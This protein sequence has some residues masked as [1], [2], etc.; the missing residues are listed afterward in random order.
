MPRNIV[1]AIDVEPDG[2]KCGPDDSW[3]GAAVTVR[4]LSAL[5]NR[6]QEGTG[7]PVRLNWFLR[8]DPQI[9]RTWGR[10]DWVAQA[11]PSLLS[12]ALNNGDFT[13][14][15][16]H[17]WRWH[18]ARGH[19][20]NDFADAAWRA[21]CLG[22]SIEGYEAV[23]GARPVASRFGDR[24]LQQEDIALLRRS[25]IRY[26]LTLEP[27]APAH[28]LSCD[29]LASCHLPDQRRAPRRP[30]RPSSEDYLAPRKRGSMR[31][32]GEDLW[33]VPMTVTRS[34]HW[35]PLRQPPFLIRTTLPLNLVL[36]PRR[37]WAQLSS[38]MDRETAEPI[39]FALRCGDLANP[40]FLASF[41]FVVQRMARHPGL[42]RCRFVGI[43]H[44]V[45][46]FARS[47]DEQG[48]GPS[49]ASHRV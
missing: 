33:L 32:P 36:R 12:T 6:L 48:Q 28:R 23:F 20:Y 39:V 27:G 4:N 21:D 42:R 14:I 43:D 35:M 31:E 3:G 29:R 19:W 5:R 40:R 7:A 17:M 13:G 18:E 8:F 26:D 11:C 25:G 9:E 1:F 24:S 16:V 46:V 44:A 37:V 30:Y 2:R 45:G 34:L 47:Q 22:S 41:H 10:R 38:E 49:I 15:H